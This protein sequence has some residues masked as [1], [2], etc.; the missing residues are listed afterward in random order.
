MGTFLWFLMKLQT[1]YGINYAQFK[2]IK[3]NQAVNLITMV[4]T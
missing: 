3:K 2:I 4:S 1:E